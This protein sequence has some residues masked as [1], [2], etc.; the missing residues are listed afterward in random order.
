MRQEELTFDL[1]VP[2]RGRP[3][4]TL[5]MARS[6]LEKAHH[7]GRVRIMFRFDHDDP[8]AAETMKLVSGLEADIRFHTGDRIDVLSNMWNEIWSMT[9]GDICWH[10]NNDMV[11]VTQGWD[12]RVAE[13]FAACPDMIMM[14]Y[15]DDGY[16]HEKIAI[17]SFTSRIATNVWGYFLPPYFKALGNDPWI[18]EV[19]QEIGRWRYL[20]D[21]FIR[22]DHWCVSPENMKFKDEVY[23]YRGKFNTEADA[24]YRSAVMQ[25]KRRQDAKKLFEYLEG[26]KT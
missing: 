8:T 17:D 26:K 1:L 5:A 2:A 15:C 9:S 7:P 23:N 12:D 14:V 6:A 10:G 20:P 22:H 25:E 4:R 19:Y 11:F 18:T 21:V 13:Q 3:E 24:L 16:Q